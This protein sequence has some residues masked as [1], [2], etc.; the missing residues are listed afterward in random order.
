MTAMGYDIITAV[1]ATAACLGNVG[2]GLGAVGPTDN[3]AALPGMAKWLMSTLM[4][5]GRIEIYTLVILLFP[6]FWKK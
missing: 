3:Y 1:G 5:M 2:P 6:T 4:L